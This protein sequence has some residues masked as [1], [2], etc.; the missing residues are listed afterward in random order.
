MET[1][2]LLWQELA[3]SGDDYQVYSAFHQLAPIELKTGNPEQAR[4]LWLKIV[5]RLDDTKRP[6][7]QGIQSR[8]FVAEQLQAHGFPVDALGLVRRILEADRASF[9]ER[10]YALY[11]IEQTERTLVDVLRGE[12]ICRHSRICH[13]STMREDRK[14]S[15]MYEK[16][17][18]IAMVIAATLVL[19]GCLT[20][21]F[22]PRQ[23]GQRYV[24]MKGLPQAP[25]WSPGSF[26]VRLAMETGI[27]RDQLS[28]AIALEPRNAPLRYVR[29]LVQLGLGDHEQ[30]CRDCRE[31][32]EQFTA[33][34]DVWQPHIVGW[35][36]CL[37]PDAVADYSPVLRWAEEC[38][39]AEPE[40]SFSQLVWGAALYRAGK[41]EEA[42]GRLTEAEQLAQESDASLEST[43]TCA[44]CFL[45][46]AHHKLRHDVEAKQWLYKATDWTDRVVRQHEDGAT[47]RSC[48]RL[49]ALKLLR[50]EAEALLKPEP[51]EGVC[52]TTGHAS[53][54]AGTW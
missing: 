33:A 29:A 13:Q 24:S 17:H 23:V 46:M 26:D 40:W 12:N 16:L 50:N 15:T 42:I 20:C 1:A 22:F 53:S 18:R 45:A 30:Y 47:T 11:L 4:R 25:T 51:T 36:C 38:A 43:V 19:G 2:T 49:L 9:S 10:S 5:D 28:T 14:M 8:A 37:A 52:E 27:D 32:V 7:E 54:E 35:T 34:G 31:A 41:Y 6:I 21:F 48:N 3:A 39:Q 44:W